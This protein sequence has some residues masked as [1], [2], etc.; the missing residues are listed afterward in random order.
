MR[1]PLSLLALLLSFAASAQKKQCGCDKDSLLNNNTTDCE[2]TFLKNGAKLYW[3][4]TCDAIWLTLELKSGKKLTLENY[5][6]E[7]SNLLYRLGYSLEKEFDNTLL[8]RSGCP[9][10]GFCNYYLID[11]NTG[12]LKDSL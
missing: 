12:A 9:A 10:N 3:Q 1:F 7:L 11:K 2:T 5:P 4:F 6:V 8:F